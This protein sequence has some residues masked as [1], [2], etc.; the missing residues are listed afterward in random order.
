MPASRSCSPNLV[1]APKK[2]ANRSQRALFIPAGPPRRQFSPQF[3]ESHT[4]YYDAPRTGQSCQEQSL[5]AENGGLNAADEL[6]VVGDGLVEAHHA[7]RV[8]LQ[9]LAR[10]QLKIDKVAA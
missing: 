1:V 9:H 6:N 5:T 8:H 3:V 2:S 4:L 10:R 7:T